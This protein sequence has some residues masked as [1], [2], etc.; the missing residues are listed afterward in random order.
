MTEERIVVGVDGSETAT[1]RSRG[2]STRHGLGTRAFASCPRGTAP[3]M[4]YPG[5]MEGADIFEKAADEI[6]RDAE[7][8]ADAHG[9]TASHRT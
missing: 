1:V 6:L 9:L 2:R 4:A 7:R 8:D 3:I 5:A